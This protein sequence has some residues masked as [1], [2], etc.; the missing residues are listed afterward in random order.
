MI[1]SEQNLKNETLYRVLSMMQSKESFDI[2]EFFSGFFLKP[3]KDAYQFDVANLIAFQ[4]IMSESDPAPLESPFEFIFKIFLKLVEGL[5]AIGS[6]IAFAID[7]LNDGITLVTSEGKNSSIGSV[8][9]KDFI[10][11]RALSY[12]DASIALT[13]GLWAYTKAFWKK[14][15]IS[16]HVKL[17]NK[18][19]RELLQGLIRNAFANQITQTEA[20]IRLAADYLNH[21]K[22]G[23]VARIPFNNHNEYFWRISQ[24]NS[25]AALTKHLLQM[26]DN[27]LDPKTNF[28]G[29]D[30]RQVRIYIAYWPSAFK[31]CERYSTA[32]F[33]MNKGSTDDIS[34]CDGVPGKDV[35]F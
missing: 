1:K 18:G 21:V 33:G 31:Q 4:A 2:D 17:S 7:L 12:P 34:M 10:A 29:S 30:N 20:F 32:E 3:F 22:A 15:K 19:D 9:W 14:H 13:N 5:P 6:E 35:T 24:I 16:T 26:T 23:I 11:S 28:K 27:C 25:N 8:S